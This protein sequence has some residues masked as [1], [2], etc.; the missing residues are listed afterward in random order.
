MQSNTLQNPLFNR[1]MQQLAQKK[2]NNASAQENKPANIALDV[3]QTHRTNVSGV[4]DA[5]VLLKEDEIKKVHDKILPSNFSTKMKIH[6]ENA[7]NIPQYAYRGLKGDPDANFY[8]FLKL[9]NIAYYTG[10]AVLTGMFALGNPG[11]NTKATIGSKTKTKMVGAGVAMYYIMNALAKKIIDVP[12]KLNTGV[13]LNHPYR[14]IVDLRAQN[15]DGMSPKKVEYH[16]VYESNEFTRWDLLYKDKQEDP[17]Q[18]NEN[19]DIIANKLGIDE[20]LNDADST[21]KP[22]VKSLIKQSTA[23]KYLLAVPA[24]V[25]GVGIG[26][27]EEMT[28]FG[29]NLINGIRNI[30]KKI[31]NTKAA[32]ISA[33]EK[34]ANKTLEKAAK[35][36]NA[37]KIDELKKHSEI[38]DDIQDMTPVKI[39][40]SFLPNIT[41]MIKSKEQKY[42]FKD[43]SIGVHEILGEIE[44]T[45]ILKETHPKSFVDKIEQLTAEKKPV[46]LTY[47][48]MNRIKETADTIERSFN[49]ELVDNVAEQS[50]KIIGSEYFEKT[51]KELPE[52]LL[53]DAKI[54][55]IDDLIKKIDELKKSTKEAKNLKQAGTFFDSANGLLKQAGELTVKTVQI[56]EKPP[57]DNINGL[58]EA[59]K[60]IN[61]SLIKP[62]TDSVKTFWHG[63]IIT[64]TT[65][66]EAANK[67]QYFSK[68]SKH[69]GKITIIG[70]AAMALIANIHL[71]LSTAKNSKKAVNVKEVNA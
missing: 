70:G 49:K 8:E 68:S 32:N 53:N 4:I 67:I 6:V 40:R 12:V 14:D 69:L 24:V 36:L 56:F 26:N 11:F 45:N 71:Y 9:G 20:Q 7:L 35:I 43:K 1:T 57:I 60:I 21:V 15:P 59:G 50:K 19:Y 27:Q 41:E 55:N 37:A 63:G 2:D 51:V 25:F 17:N 33:I 54:K 46:E 5:P 66:E 58:K 61:T 3:Q 64:N 52:Q 30:P 18:V 28:K 44:K 23:W 38:I 16:N 65:V 34:Q 22:T 13:D 62:F 31:K 29:N 47:E 39:K 48:L 42:T 10:G